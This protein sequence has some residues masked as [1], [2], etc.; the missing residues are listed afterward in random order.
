MDNCN[1]MQ[2]TKA[3]WVK[4]PCGKY[5]VAKVDSVEA[6]GMGGGDGLGRSEFH[7]YANCS[8][9]DSSRILARALFDVGNWFCRMANKIP[10]LKTPKIYD[11]PRQ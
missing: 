10:K 9:Y 2:L 5:E 8:Y 11:V 3:E 7:S 4:C 6:Y 1:Q